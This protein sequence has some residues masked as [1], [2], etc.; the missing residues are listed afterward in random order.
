[1]VCA[2]VRGTPIII[3]WTRPRLIGFAWTGRRPLECGKRPNDADLLRL[4]EAPAMTRL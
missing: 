4:R 3:G 1:M 2:R